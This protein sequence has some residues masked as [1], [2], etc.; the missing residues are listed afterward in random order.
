MAKTKKHPGTIEQRGSSH[1]IILY[2]GGER[3]TYT[4]KDSTREEAIAYAKTKDDELQGQIE[5][6]RLGLPGPMPFSALLDRYEAEKIPLLSENTRRAYRGSLDRFKDYFVSQGGDPRVH[7]IRAGHVRG[8]LNWRRVHKLRG[9]TKGKEA[10]RPAS[11]RTLQ[12]DRAVLHAVLSFAAELEII[13]ANPVRKVT[14]PKADKRDPIILSEEQFEELLAKCE[15]HPMLWLYV[16]ALGETGGRCESE[17]LFVQWPDV[18]LQEGFLHIR[19]GRGGHRT[20]SGKG[21]FVPLTPRLR[22][23]FRQQFA[24]FRMATYNGQRSPWVFHHPYARRR[25]KAGDRLGSLRRAFTAAV[26]RAGLP[27]EIHQ[28]D[29]RHRRVT[30]W[31]AEGKSAALVREAMGHADLRTTL[32]YSHLAKEHLRALVD[33]EP[34]RERL[35]ELGS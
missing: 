27:P 11:A 3:H 2:A 16:L 22:E 14:P 20:K 33:P 31:L 8:F 9:V 13:D 10:G 35:K 26:K 4:L 17:I 18:D 12:K 1:R 7:E 24:T 30:T 19:S 23:A 29:L 25:A 32:G 15:D 6:Q 5:R 21:R 28:H 34:E